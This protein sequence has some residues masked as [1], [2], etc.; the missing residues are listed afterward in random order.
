MATRPYMTYSLSINSQIFPFT[1]SPLI[2]LLLVTFIKHTKN[3]LSSRPLYPL[4]LEHSSSRFQPSILIS[5]RSWCNSHILNKSYPN[6]TFRTF[7]RGTKKHASLF[8]L[9]LKVCGIRATVAQSRRGNVC[10][11]PSIIKARPLQV[12]FSEADADME[13]GVQELY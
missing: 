1:H 4:F 5:V 9:N 11:I 13:F 2:R 6:Q 8:Y 10:I 3:S 12:G 7:R